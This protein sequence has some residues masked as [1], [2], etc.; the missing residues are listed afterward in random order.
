MAWPCRSNYIYV[1][2]H[3][4]LH[5]QAPGGCSKELTKSGIIDWST[6]AFGANNNSNYYQW[7]HFRAR[8]ARTIR[9]MEEQGVPVIDVRMLYQRTDAHVGS[10]SGDDPTVRY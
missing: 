6:Y 10:Q 2:M 3:G 1:C 4:T 8:D 7:D 9:K 5:R